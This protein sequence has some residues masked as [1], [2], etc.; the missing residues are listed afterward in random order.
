MGI[1]DFEIAE[2]FEIELF[3]AEPLIA[4]SVA[5]EIDE[6]GKI[7]VVEM[8]GYPIDKG[9]TGKVKIL[10]D[11]DADGYPDQSVIFADSLVLP[12]GIGSKQLNKITLIWHLSC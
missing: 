3:A 6:N 11:T 4:D 2:D 7:Y 5:M 10:K 12:T 9:G 8:H 1:L